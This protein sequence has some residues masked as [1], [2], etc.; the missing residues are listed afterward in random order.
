MSL[1]EEITMLRRRVKEQDKEI[2]RLKEENEFLEKTG[3]NQ[4]MIF[5]ALKTEDGRIT[6]KIS[7]YSRL[8]P[9]ICRC[10]GAGEW[11]TSGRHCKGIEKQV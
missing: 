9:S 8:I 3:K 10:A 6:G 11:G 4:R 7:F 1:S 2:R 5:L